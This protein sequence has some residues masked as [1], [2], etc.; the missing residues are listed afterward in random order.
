MH[1]VCACV[2][3]CQ[4][5]CLC[6]V[7][8]PVDLISV[9]DNLSASSKLLSRCPFHLLIPFSSGLLWL[10]LALTSKDCLPVCV[11][12][13]HRMKLGIWRRWAGPLAWGSIPSR[14]DLGLQPSLGIRSWNNTS[15][16]IHLG[17]G[18]G[19]TGG[20]DLEV[21]SYST[22]KQIPTW[23]DVNESVLGFE[24]WYLV[25][26]ADLP[27]FIV[28]IW[29]FPCRKVFI[30]SPWTEFSTGWKKASEAAFRPWWEILHWMLHY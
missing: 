21:F 27:Y 4:H 25:T 16:C 18:S 5:V 20:G 22:A 28:L 24:S 17:G 11:P 2:C 13:K 9:S 7:S 29:P 3:V 1:R 26:C 8:S 10:P 6:D 19:R 15:N 30:V 14:R 12:K 23:S